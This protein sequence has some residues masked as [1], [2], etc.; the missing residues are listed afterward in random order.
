[1]VHIKKRNFAEPESR[2]LFYIMVCQM[3]GY[4]VDQIVTECAT[5]MHMAVS[6]TWVYTMIRKME[7]VNAE[8]FHNMKKSNTAYI[9]EVMTLK[10]HL[11]YYR[12]II[13]SVL[14]GE[15]FKHQLTINQILKLLEALYKLDETQFNMLREMPK[16]FAWGGM[17]SSNGGPVYG[18]VGDEHSEKDISQYITNLEQIPVPTDLEELQTKTEDEKLG[19]HLQKDPLS[20]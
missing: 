6:K 2:L 16:M 18:S 12:E 3:K 17:R 9:N 15:E 4:S 10:N 13:M 7:E 1:M 20:K 5:N 8:T 14:K 19:T 11:D